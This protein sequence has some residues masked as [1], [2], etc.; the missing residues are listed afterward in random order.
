MT[1]VGDEPIGTKLDDLKDETHESGT[2][3]G[4]LKLDG[5]TTDVGTA[6]YELSGVIAETGTMKAWLLTLDGIL[7]DSTTTYDG[8]DV[9]VI[10]YEAGS[11]ET[12]LAEITYGVDHVVGIVTAVT[13]DGDAHDDCHEIQFGSGVDSHDGVA[14][15]CENTAE[16]YGSA[17][18]ALAAKARNKK[19]KMETLDIL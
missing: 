4:D 15:S 12:S 11:V 2:R 6:T 3:T 1:A 17:F 7:V 19:A 16:Q 14:I 8:L 18:I 5:T 13:I 10:T 9:I